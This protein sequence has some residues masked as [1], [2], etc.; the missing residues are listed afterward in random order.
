MKVS[1][2]LL[3]EIL[4]GSYEEGL[5]FPDSSILWSGLRKLS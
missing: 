4:L 3:K 2:C 5:V 1:W